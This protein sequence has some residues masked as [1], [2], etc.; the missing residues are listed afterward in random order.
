MLNLVWIPVHGEEGKQPQE[1]MHCV[2]L[3]EG[4]VGWYVSVK[5]QT[6]C[7]AVAPEA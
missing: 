5:I 7:L 6:S 1:L 2:S 3:A 4:E